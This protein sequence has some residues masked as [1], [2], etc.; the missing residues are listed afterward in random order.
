MRR[1]AVIL[2]VL[3]MV[4]VRQEGSS[5]AWGGEPA[6]ARKE[7]RKAAERTL[8]R[9]DVDAK[10]RRHGRVF[11][12]EVVVGKHEVRKAFELLADPGDQPSRLWG[13]RL[14]QSTRSQTTFNVGTRRAYRALAASQSH[15]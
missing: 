7:W 10:V 5:V 2:A 6:K 13:E 12:L 4:M 9:A 1:A 8:R 15:L 11:D 3:T 14:L